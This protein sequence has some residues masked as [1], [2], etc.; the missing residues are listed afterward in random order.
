MFF[1]AKEKILSVQGSTT[2]YITFG[3]GERTLVMIQGLNTNGI[4]GAALP[5]ALAYRCFSGDY[6]VYLFDR[7]DDLPENV[8]VRHLADDLAA[9]MDALELK[10]ADVLGVSEGGMIAQYLAI[11]RPDLV[12]SLV[13]A[14]T[15]SRSNATVE[16]AVNGWVEMTERG[17]MKA[18][19][20]DMAEKMYSDSYLKRYK[21][22]LPLLT[23]LQRPKDKA[24]F[25]DLAKSCLTCDTYGELTKIKCP[26]LVIGGGRDKIVGADAL[27]ELRVALDCETYVYEELGHACYEEAKDF[28]TRVLEFFRKVR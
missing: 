5:L 18:L 17:D 19:I 26:V 22:L 28:N 8:T 13:L 15:L 27:Y 21:P 2:R 1:N 12:H 23:V 9:Y 25:I 14:V 24:R 7:A 4:K 6:T 3:K 10:N 16:G 11:G 20:T